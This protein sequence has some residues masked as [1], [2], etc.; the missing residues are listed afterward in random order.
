M[1]SCEDMAHSTSRY[2]I[3]SININ[4]KLRCMTTGKL[5]PIA[6]KIS[7]VL[8]LLH[9]MKKKAPYPAV[10][11]CYGDE[12]SAAFPWDQGHNWPLD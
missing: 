4:T 11:A 9:F 3:E 2:T 12:R 10:F 1:R 6:A 5:L 7:L 8:S